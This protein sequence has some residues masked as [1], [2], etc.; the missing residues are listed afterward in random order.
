MNPINVLP[1][2]IMGRTGLMAEYLLEQGHGST[3]VVDFTGM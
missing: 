3:A 1:T 2:A